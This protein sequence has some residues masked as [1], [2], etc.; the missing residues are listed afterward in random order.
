MAAR[1]NEPSF[2]DPQR[3]YTRRGFINASGI[4]ETRIREAKRRG[5]ELPWLICGKR[6]FLRGAD[7]IKFIERLAQL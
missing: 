3:L 4:S 5:I 6:K 1:R 2:I 7:A